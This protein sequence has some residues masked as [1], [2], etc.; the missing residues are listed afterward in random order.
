MTEPNNHDRA[1]WAFRSVQK[2]QQ[3]TG[4]DREDA[5]ADLV[6]DLCHLADEW[7][8]DPIE[9]VRRGLRMYADERD[10]GPDGWA[11]N[12]KMAHVEI[13]V[14][15]GPLEIDDPTC[16]CV[17]PGCQVCDEDGELTEKANAKI[18]PVPAEPEGFK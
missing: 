2:F 6:A 15:R 18:G 8:Q 4:T 1:E 12:D 9:Q 13:N 11:P 17:E 3:L 14:R 5:I 10:Y 7:G 16:Q